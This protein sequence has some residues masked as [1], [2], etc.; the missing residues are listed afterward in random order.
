MEF[1]YTPTEYEIKLMV[2]YTVK[3][4]KVASNYTMLDFVISSSADVNYFE[5]ERYI[6]DLMSTQNL[7][8]YSA[9]GDKFYAITEAGEETVGFFERKIPG[10]IRLKL[11]DKID[12]INRENARG[13]KI[14]A[15]YIP[16]NEN[17]YSV[18]LSLEDNGAVIL[19]LEFYA[20]PKERA[21]EICT[22]LRKNTT[23]FYKAFMELVD[24]GLQGKI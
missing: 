23:E 24:Q 8:S 16:I 21:S 4:L 2:L 17:E 13:N 20:G 22:Y 6:T 18:K 14:F 3:N 9:D 1:T 7:T 10:S 19:N 15:D 11:K 5:L 12:E